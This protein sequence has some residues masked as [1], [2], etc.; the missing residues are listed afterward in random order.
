TRQQVLPT[1]TLLDIFDASERTDLDA[2]NIVSRQ[3]IQLIRR[4][5]PLRTVDEVTLSRDGRKKVYRTVFFYV[6]EEERQLELWESSSNAAD[7]IAFF[8]LALRFCHID[9]PLKIR[10]VSIDR[11]FLSGLTS[12]KNDFT[13]NGSLLS[14]DSH[15]CKQED[16][17]PLDALCAFPSLRA[18]NYSTLQFLCPWPCTVKDE[19][20]SSLASRGIFEIGCVMGVPGVFDNGLPGQDVTEDGI[21]DFCFGDYDDG[22]KE[23]LLHVT[24]AQLTSQF[25]RRLVEACRASKSNHKLTLKIAIS[26]LMGDLEL[27]VD[28]MEDSAKD[29][30]KWELSVDGMD[31]RVLYHPWGTRYDMHGLIRCVR[32]HGRQACPLF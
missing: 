15:A 25:V 24:D 17:E 22:G 18:L 28:G 21:L 8:F 27:A 29:G 32:N 12:V 14:L 9:G 4:A 16:V 10:S 31:L 19:F 5:K 26:E 2:W 20:L 6:D 23:R 7:H 1:D 13:F 11:D 3:Y 30:S